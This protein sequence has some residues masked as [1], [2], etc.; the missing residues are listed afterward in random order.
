MEGP[1]RFISTAP[2]ATSLPISLSNP[3]LMH[4]RWPYWVVASRG[5]ESAHGASLEPY[6][7][8][9]LANIHYNCAG[10]RQL[11]DLSTESDNFWTHNEDV[12]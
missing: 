7:S 11:F 1:P 12:R 5:F 8:F 10:D 6:Y 3:Q 2:P 9:C 4:L